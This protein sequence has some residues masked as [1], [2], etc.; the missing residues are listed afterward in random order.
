MEFTIQEL[1]E[2]I[3]SHPNTSILLEFGNPVED[4][5]EEP[6]VKTMV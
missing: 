6:C 3:Q 1:K 4:R 2:Y 5:K